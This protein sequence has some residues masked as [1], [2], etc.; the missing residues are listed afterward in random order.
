VRFL[1]CEPLLGPID[2]PLRCDR[3]GYARSDQMIH[4]DHR[5]CGGEIPGIDWVIV[6]GES[7]PGARPCDVAWIRSIV[8]QCR[9]AGVPAFVKH[10][11]AYVILDA[12]YDRS[13]SGWTRRLRD[14]KGGDPDEWPSDLRVR[15]FPS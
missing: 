14:R 3:C 6:G 15:E 4:G 7:G 8:E 1:S 12:R 2:L 10:L 5:L 13:I 9:A 11:G